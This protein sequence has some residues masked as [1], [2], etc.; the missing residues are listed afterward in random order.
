MNLRDRFLFVIFFIV[1]QL[2]IE[3]ILHFTRIRDLST[4]VLI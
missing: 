2:I 4:Q 1:Y 3:E